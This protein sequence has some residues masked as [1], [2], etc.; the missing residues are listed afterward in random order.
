MSFPLVCFLVIKL[1]YSFRKK[2]KLCYFFSVGL[3]K[4]GK[5]NWRGISTTRS[6]V[7]HLLRVCKCRTHQKQLPKVSPSF[8]TLMQLSSPVQHCLLFLFSFENQKFLPHCFSLHRHWRLETS[9]VRNSY[10]FEFVA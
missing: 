3:E 1:Y 10:R 7:I 6:L 4:L 8:E 2:K 5:G 9:K